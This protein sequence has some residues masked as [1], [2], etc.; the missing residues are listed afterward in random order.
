MNTQEKLKKFN[1]SK[2]VGI[3]RQAL[4]SKFFP[5]ITALIVV[6]CY[7]LSWDMVTIW[8]IGLCGMAIL[9]LL[10]DITPIISL[11]LFMNIMISWKNS[12][13]PVAGNSQYYFHPAVLAQIGIIIAV[14]VLIAIF[15]VV[16][17][18]KK[19]NFRL[20]PTFWGLCAFAFTMIVSGAFAR[21]YTA[22]NLVYGLFMAFFFLFVFVLG[23]TNIKVN[24]QT[25]EKI[26]WGF[27]AL[28]VCLII[29]LIVA[30]ATYDGLIVDGRIIRGKLMFGWGVYNTMGMLFTISLPSAAYLAIKYNHGWVFTAYLAIIM[31]FTYLTFSRQAMLCGTI[32]FFLCVVAIFLK[33]KNDVAHGAVLLIW[34]VVVAILSKVFSGVINATLTN[35]SENFF[36]GSGRIDLWKLGLEYFVKNPVFGVGFFAPVEGDPGSTGLEIIPRMYHNTLIQVLATGGAVALIAYLVHRA[37]TVISYFKNPTF[38]RTYVAF[39]IGALLVLSLLDNHMFY[40]LPTLVYSMLVAV[41]INSEKTGNA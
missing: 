30:Y 39:T 18:V 27:I 28:S 25:F 38:D 5:F 22:M 24:G 21:G 14:Y 3:I 11:F 2:A 16:L 31:L 12:P 36:G 7:Y 10:D 35:I 23:S 8:Y 33:G 26:A 41:L 19:G 40:I 9:L 13:S 15:K 17:S 6:A 4:S 1:N 29:E 34:F 37:Q 20:T 32:V